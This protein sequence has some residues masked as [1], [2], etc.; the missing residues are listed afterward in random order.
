MI[1][2]YGKIKY[3]LAR[4]E[5]KFKCQKFVKKSRGGNRHVWEGDGGDGDPLT[6]GDLGA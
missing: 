3:I 2:E 5:R 6:L 1:R 4:G